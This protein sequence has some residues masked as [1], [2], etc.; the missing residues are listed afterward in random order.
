MQAG[1]LYLLGNIVL[2]SDIERTVHFPMKCQVL[3]IFA[4]GMNWRNEL[5]CDQTRNCFVLLFVHL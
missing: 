1:N 2:K 3:Y 4:G 5:E